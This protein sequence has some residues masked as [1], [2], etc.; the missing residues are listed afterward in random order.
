MADIDAP[1][2][3][4]VS[5][6]QMRISA[7]ERT[8]E[9]PAAH[10]DPMPTKG[11]PPVPRGLPM[12]EDT[13][14]LWAN[15]AVLSSR[16][17]A[18]PV[19]AVTSPDGGAG[20]STLTAAVGGMLAIAS[21]GPVIAVDGAPR[22]WSGLGDRIGVQNAMTFNDL[23]THGD[24]AE[25]PLP[26]DLAEPYVQHGPTGLRLVASET[27]PD[28]STRPVLDDPRLYWT[29][30]R[31][32]YAYRLALVDAPP[33]PDR[34]GIQALHRAK[35]VMLVARATPD[36]IDHALAWLSWLRADGLA[37]L[38]DRAVVV[39]N[40]V[41]P[42]P[43]REVRAGERRLLGQAGRVL[44]LP[45]DRQLTRPEPIDPLRLAKPTRNAVLAIAAAV[46]TRCVSSRGA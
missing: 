39:V 32:R 10:V 5:L 24:G 18:F 30:A 16:Q 40:E 41:H 4:P 9:A 38:A 12:G 1:L 15:M 13:Q 45:F 28:P 20:C 14:A 22:P 46:A 6:T 29:L 33:T 8:E 26:F 25:A 11:V 42:D 43:Q 27:R 17:G 23:L 21:R 31:L 37:E 34:I 44:R 7:P 2:T 19:V 3:E 35:L 36:S